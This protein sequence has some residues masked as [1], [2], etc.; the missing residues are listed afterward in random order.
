MVS[1]TQDK[2]GSSVATQANRGSLQKM[3]LGSLLVGQLDQAINWCNDTA[4]KKPECKPWVDLP[5]TDATIIH[6]S[7]SSEPIPAE[8]AKTEEE[9]PGAAAVSEPTTTDVPEVVVADIVSES[10]PTTESIVASKPAVTNELEQDE[11]PAVV[12]EAKVEN[13]V[14]TAQG[15]ISIANQPPID[16]KVDST[17]DSDVNASMTQKPSLPEPPAVRTTIEVASTRERTS[18][19]PTEVKNPSKEKELDEAPSKPVPTQSA[20]TQSAPTQSA[21]TQSAPTIALS[22]ESTTVVKNLDS[23]PPPQKSRAFDKPA[24]PSSVRPVSAGQ[25][26][27]EDYLLQLERLVVELNMELASA[28][29]EQEA[30]DPLEQ[31]ANR[32]IALNLENLALREKLQRTNQ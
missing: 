15:V 4:F 17:L 3:N 22:K 12:V 19:A 5:T 21:P 16:A 31:M 11:T 7:T 23:T 14:E 29:G 20:P 13:E 10:D 24:L 32:I 27:Q 9:V 26:S 28:R 2:V 6:Q 8:E 30:I 25:H 18:T 1:E